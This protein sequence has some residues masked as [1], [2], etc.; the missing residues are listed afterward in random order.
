ME[1]LKCALTYDEH[2]CGFN[3]CVE[4]G[5]VTR[6]LALVVGSQFTLNTAQND[7]FVA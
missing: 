4:S 5:L 6:N 1:G 2:Q 7:R 3:I